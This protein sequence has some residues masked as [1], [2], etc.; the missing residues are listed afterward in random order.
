MYKTMYELLTGHAPL[1]ALVPVERIYETGSVEDRPQTPFLVLAWQPSYQSSTRQ[2]FQRQLEVHAHDERGSHA[3]L[4][5]VMAA[6]KTCLEGA[7]QFQGSDGWITCCDF[8]GDGGELVDPET[9]TNLQFSS[10]RVVGRT[11]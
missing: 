5:Q 4:R 1:T 6:V 7:T 8:A 11:T 2:P 10:W 9:S 3:L